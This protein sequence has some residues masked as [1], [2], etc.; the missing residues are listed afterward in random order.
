MRR[1]KKNHTTKSTS[2]APSISERLTGDVL[3]CEMEQQKA[4]NREI[5]HNAE[6]MLKSAKASGDIGMAIK[7]GF[8]AL[9]CDDSSCKTIEQQSR[10]LGII[11]DQQTI[12]VNTQVNQL[13]ILQSPEWVELRSTILQALEPYEL[14]RSAV[15]LALSSPGRHI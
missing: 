5:H 10:I 3:L 9:K 1:H 8:L 7:A 4:S 6:E 12:N 11:K 2:Y 14:A 15:V 13:N